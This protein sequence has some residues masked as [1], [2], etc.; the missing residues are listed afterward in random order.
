M[1]SNQTACSQ[2]RR[3]P[4]RNCQKTS[5]DRKSVAQAEQKSGVD[6]KYV[7]VGIAGQH[8]RSHQHRGNIIRED[9]DKEIS[10][11]EIDCLT[12]NM[13]KLSMAPGEEII[14]V[15]AQEYIIDGEGGIRQPAGML[16]NTLEANF[17]IIIGQTAAAKNILNIGLGT[18]SLASA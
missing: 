3:H 10:A 6:I 4:V 5:G 17:H 9:P 14:D 16:G 1:G 12:Q 13:Y 7:N 2:V 8:I 18:Q 11:A 15:I